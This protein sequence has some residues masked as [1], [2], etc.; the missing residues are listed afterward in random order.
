VRDAPQGEADTT[1]FQAC[2]EMGHIEARDWI[3]HEQVEA[4]LG[5][6]ARERGFPDDEIRDK[7]ERCV[8]K[9]KLE[10]HP[11]LDARPVVRVGKLDATTTHAEE[12]LLAAGVQLYQRDKA[13]VRPV[14]ADVD[15]SHGRRTKVAQ[16]VPVEKAYLRRLLSRVARWERQ[17][18]RSKRGWVSMA[19]PP[20]EIGETILAS[21]GEW[22]FPHLVGVITTPTMRPDTA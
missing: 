19:N 6:A 10:P 3:S 22:K 14:V 18:E 11:D 20:A 8:E 17:D 5:A 4:E 7:L 15:A 9:G 16:L 2:K 1:F 21:V 12:V 13:L